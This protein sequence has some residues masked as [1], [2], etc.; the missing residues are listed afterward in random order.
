MNV[1]NA[2]NIETH[3]SPYAATAGDTSKRF[4]AMELNL[5]SSG[6]FSDMGK[7]LN[8]EYRKLLSVDALNLLVFARGARDFTLVAD[9]GARM[10]DCPVQVVNYDRIG[11]YT[12]QCK[13][14]V[15]IGG[16]SEDIHSRFFPNCED[17][18]STIALLPL[19][20]RA[21]I[22]G[23]LA[24]ANVESQGI[25]RSMGHEQLNRLA[26][27][28]AVCVENLYNQEHIRQVGLHDPLTGL[29][30]RRYF[31]DHIDQELARSMRG[32]WPVSCIYLDIDYFKLV[33]DKYGHAAGD[34]VLRTL[35]ERIG[36]RLR[37]GEVFARMGGEE[38]CILLSD[39][40]ASLGVLVA[41]RIRAE[42]EASPVKLPFGR[43]VNVTI[44]C[45]VADS[46]RFDNADKAAAA[47]DLV[48]RADHALYQAKQGGRNKVVADD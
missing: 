31:T 32:D 11:N 48:D 25:P 14:G 43:E 19:S 45:G 3:I 17:N 46:T 7:A 38:F 47:D 26:A 22:I 6:S 13:S 23:I 37:S 40:P 21:K 8:C 36:K 28:V 35:C 18:L 29:F 2:L 34:A 30:N 20:R 10:A 9:D 33:N 4:Q 39:T 1:G 16:Y 12:E 5:L 42:V 41:E 44:S 24:L 27:I 15:W